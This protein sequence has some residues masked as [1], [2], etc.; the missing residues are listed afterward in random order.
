MEPGTS[1]ILYA[2]V[3]AFLLIMLGVGIAAKR[4]VSDTDDFLRG[5]CRVPWWVAGTSMYMGTFSAFSFVSYGS[6]VFTDGGV[7][8]LT[9]YGTVL[10]YLIAGMFFAHR[11]HRASLVTP[12]EYLERRFGLAA[13]QF[14]GCA[15]I[16]V[17]AISSALKL[18]AFALMTEGLTGAP[19][20]PTLLV[21][22]A[23]MAVVAIVGGLWG[24][25]LADAVQFVVLLAGLI[26]LLIMSILALGGW[27]AF[28]ELAQTDL[29]AVGRGSRDWDW[30]ATWWLLQILS[31]NFS[32]PVIQRFSSVPTEK[33]ARKSAF[34]TAALLLPTPFLALV[35]VAICFELF[36]TTA[37]EMAFAHM[38]REVLPIGLLGLMAG[39]MIAATVSELET[40]F[41]ID[42]GV[43]TRDIYQRWMR[44]DATRRHLLWVSRVST[45]ASATVAIALAVLLA[46]SRTGIF[47]FSE[48]FGSRVVLALAIPCIVGILIRRV[49]ERAFFFTVAASLLASLA[50][51]TFGWSAGDVRLPLIAAGLLALMVGAYVFPPRGAEASRAQ[52]FFATLAVPN[53]AVSADLQATDAQTLRLV[54][55]AIALMAFIPLSLPFLAGTTGPARTVEYGIALFLM[56]TSAGLLLARRRFT[57]ARGAVIAPVNR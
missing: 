28:M 34:L 40:A 35:P 10:G 21:T 19:V 17:N 8:I 37:P 53:P 54:A 39:A 4:F 27:D 22:G 20:V 11:W 26:P 46:S 3:G 5:G 56:L 50:F 23:A 55:A 32:F 52:E 30:L 48:A 43:F 2:V 13:R 24:I 18:Y 44:P 29:L 16:G 47:D 31:V 1:W 6:V 33:Q 41:N 42:S 57:P 45:L 25:V 7:G 49:S 14:V 36:P 51:W 15:T 9:G 12:A 38:A